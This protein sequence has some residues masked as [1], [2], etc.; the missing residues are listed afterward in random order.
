MHGIGRHV[1]AQLAVLDCAR[2]VVELKLAHR[3]GDLRTGPVLVEF[4]PCAV[5]GPGVLVRVSILFPVG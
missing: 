3:A 4:V 1:D 2:R 5:C